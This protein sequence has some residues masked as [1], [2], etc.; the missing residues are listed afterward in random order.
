MRRLLVLWTAC[1]AL[2]GYAQDRPNILLSGI[3]EEHFNE[4]A[5]LTKG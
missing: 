5:E 2:G 3:E 4:I 1:W